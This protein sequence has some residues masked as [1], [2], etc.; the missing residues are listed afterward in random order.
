MEFP[1]LL[2]DALSS[3]AHNTVLLVYALI[4]IATIYSRI[5]TRTTSTSAN[6]P[7]N[8]RFSSTRS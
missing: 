1:T 5:D 6:T 4:A 8:A 2:P 7:L 3:V